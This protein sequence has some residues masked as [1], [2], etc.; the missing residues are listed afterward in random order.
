MIERR[1][2]SGQVASWVVHGPAAPQVYRDYGPTHTAK[3]L[4]RGRRSERE[5]VDGCFWVFL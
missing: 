2:R 4:Q 1:Q 3:S 5:T